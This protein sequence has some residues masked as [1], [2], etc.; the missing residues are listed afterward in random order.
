M[1]VSRNTSQLRSS[2]LPPT[3]SNAWYMGTVPTGTGLLRRIHSRVSWIS[4]PV[5][6]SISVSPPHLQLH[7]ALSTSSSMPDDMEELPILV[8]IFTRKSVPMIIGSASGWL[9]LAGMTARPSAIFW[10]TN[11]GVINVLIPRSSQSMFS[12]MATYSISS[13]MMPSRAQSMIVFPFLRSVHA[14]RSF[15]RPLR[16]SISTSGSL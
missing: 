15:G 12:R 2:G 6:R 8:L 9:I 11:S 10:R 16:R 1:S 5:D 14:L 13:V 3:F 7:T 4:S